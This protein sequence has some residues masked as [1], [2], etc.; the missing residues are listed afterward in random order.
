MKYRILLVSD[1]AVLGVPNGPD[2]LRESFAT[3]RPK[4]D[5]KNDSISV[6]EIRK[7]DRIS[8]ALAYEQRK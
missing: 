8:E 7:V 5:G 4:T 3:R 6:R 1:C 2:G